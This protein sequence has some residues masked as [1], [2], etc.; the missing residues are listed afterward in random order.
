VNDDSSMN[1]KAI[2]MKIF[3][4]VLNQLHVLEET[5]CNALIDAH[6]CITHLIMQAKI[7]DSSYQPAHFLKWHANMDLILSEIVPDESW[8][9]NLS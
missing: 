9:T 4:P 3:E 7:E 1:Y 8:S 2:A 6:C 5:V